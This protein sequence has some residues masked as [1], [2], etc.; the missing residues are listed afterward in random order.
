MKTIALICLATLVLMTSA[1]ARIG[2][3]EAEI[4]ARYGKS[5]PVE[6]TNGLPTKVYTFGGMLIR[7]VYLDGK[8]AVEHYSHDG[9]NDALS[10][11]EISKILDANG[12]GKKWVQ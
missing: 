1:L 2:E 10:D 11:N 4:E 6:A 12:G 9:S 7:V 3:T 8:S 5:F